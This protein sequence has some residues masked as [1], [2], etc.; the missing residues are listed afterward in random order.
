MP[1]LFTGLF[2][3][4]YTIFVYF[5]VLSKK[6][7]DWSL[8]IAIFCVTWIV[9]YILKR[10]ID[11]AAPDQNRS[12]SKVVSGYLIIFYVACLGK[13]QFFCTDARLFFA[14]TSFSASYFL[15]I[16]KSAKEYEYDS[17]T[18]RCYECVQCFLAVVHFFF[19]YASIIDKH[20]KSENRDIYV[21]YQ[22][23]LSIIW[24]LS[25]FDLYA[26]LI[27]NLKLK[28]SVERPTARKNVPTQ[29]IVKRVSNGKKEKKV[30][31]DVVQG[32]QFCV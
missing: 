25:S 7:Q 11:Y 21:L 3:V 22:V 5:N 19:L 14:A 13:C 18:S 6:D 30:S 31:G 10:L 29:V 9:V 24:A 2:T 20:V 26:I 15:L 32:K 4:L 1:C 17:K 16:R 12:W 8:I 27:G 28:K 23:V